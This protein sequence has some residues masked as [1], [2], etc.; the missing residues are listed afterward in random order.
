M[1]SATTCVNLGGIILSEVSQME[2]DKYCMTS[3]IYGTQKI[4]HTYEYNKK[5]T[6]IGNKPVV[7]S[8]DRGQ[9]EIQISGV[10]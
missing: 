3:L 6:D 9:G 7:T 10:K 2:K 8:G 5:E 1:P 4:Q